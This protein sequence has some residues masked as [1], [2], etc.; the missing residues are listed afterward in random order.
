MCDGNQWT[1]DFLRSTHF[2]NGDE[3]P[4]VQ[5]NTDWMNLISPGR[6][7]Y[8]Q[9]D[10]PVS[11]GLAGNIIGFIYNWFVVEDERGIAPNGWRVA[12]K[13]DWDNIIECLGDQ[14]VTLC[15][16]VCMLFTVSFQT[17]K[18][19]ENETYFHYLSERLQLL[20]L[21]GNPCL[22]QVEKFY[23]LFSSRTCLGLR[24][25]LHL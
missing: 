8:F 14:E 10:S 19:W 20:H 11:E 5:D 18:I 6:S 12:T 1:I 13:D 23:L 24:P 2:N 16:S 4:L 25:E 21:R 9:N 15:L 22:Q 7:Y 3:I 17:K